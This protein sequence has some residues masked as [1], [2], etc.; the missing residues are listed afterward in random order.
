MRNDPRHVGPWHS[1]SHEFESLQLLHLYSNQLGR[2]QS[3]LQ[4]ANRTRKTR[5]RIGVLRPRRQRVLTRSRS[6]RVGTAVPR[7]TDANRTLKAVRHLPQ[8]GLPGDTA[9]AYPSPARSL[10][11]PRSARIWSIR[12]SASKCPSLPRTSWTRRPRSTACAS[13][14]ISASEITVGACCSRS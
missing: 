2:A 11:A 12:L 4:V 14:L 1:V 13:P 7:R 5:R 10:L 8:H 3:L 6:G 9:V